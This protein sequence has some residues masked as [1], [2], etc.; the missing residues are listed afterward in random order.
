MLKKLI[1]SVICAIFVIG[2]SLMMFMALFFLLPS[3]KAGASISLPS[4]VRDTES[5]KAKDSEEDTEEEEDKDIYVAD[6]YESLTLRTQPDSDNHQGDVSL[7]QMTHMKLL[8]FIDGTDYVYVQV[9]SGEYSGSKGYVNKQYI[10][11][12]GEHTIRVNSDQ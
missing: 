11:K 3:R 2:T 6:V 10:T 1:I 7:P 8:E 12:L 9:S 4:S 5:E